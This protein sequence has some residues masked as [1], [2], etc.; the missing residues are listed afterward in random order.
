MEEG[1]AKKLLSWQAGS[2]APA[3]ASRDPSQLPILTLGERPEGL[4]GDGPALHIGGHRLLA[5]KS[6]D[7]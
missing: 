4:N 3:D 7:P 2:A 5:V 1:P 6:C